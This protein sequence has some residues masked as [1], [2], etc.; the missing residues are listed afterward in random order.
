MIQL[1][2]H[3]ENCFLPAIHYLPNISGSY[4]ALATVSPLLAA[5]RVEVIRQPNFH[6]LPAVSERGLEDFA[7]A[8]G[9]GPK[10]E[11][12]EVRGLPARAGEASGGGQAPAVTNGF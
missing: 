5:F 11:L 7:P 12:G 8:G 6:N 10:P 4:R 2:V 9:G 3:T 1:Q